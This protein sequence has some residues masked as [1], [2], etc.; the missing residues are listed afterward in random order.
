M[1]LDVRVLWDIVSRAR[2]EGH[3]E[4]SM[5]ITGQSNGRFQN[6]YHSS[7]SAWPSRVFLG[8]METIFD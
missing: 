2:T 1:F 6:T 4:P 3:D 5:L 7:A 8:V